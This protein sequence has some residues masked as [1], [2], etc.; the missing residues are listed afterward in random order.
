MKTA[1]TPTVNNYSVATYSA[2]SVTEQVY[3]YCGQTV[4]RIY[5]DTPTVSR[6]ISIGLNINSMF[7]DSVLEEYKKIEGF[8]ETINKA[9]DVIE[10][11]NTYK[12]YGWGNNPDMHITLMKECALFEIGG[13]GNRYD[14]PKRLSPFKL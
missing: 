1:F 2:T 6:Y 12:I 11:N 13:H 3:R 10:T 5:R 4:R 7:K 8:I 14:K 9:F